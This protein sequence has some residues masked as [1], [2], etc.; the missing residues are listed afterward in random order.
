VTGPPSGIQAV[1]LYGPDGA[2]AYA[3][4]RGVQTGV[5]AVIVR[6]CAE[7]HAQTV[8]EIGCGTAAH[9]HAVQA[10]TG[11][12]GWGVDPSPSMLARRV[13][14]AGGLR[15]CC[16]CAEALPC[17]SGTVDVVFSV[18]VAH[19]VA[20]LD[21]AFHEG[22][23]VLRP[24]GLLLTATDSEAT[25]R[26]RPVLSGYFPETV[27]HELARY[28]S[29]GRLEVAHSRC[30][31]EIVETFVAE[32][33]YVVTDARPFRERAYSCLHLISDAALAAGI[34]RLERDLPLA[35]VSRNLVIIARRNRS[36]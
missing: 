2:A 4:F 18:D 12:R 28:P 8:L 23:R 32:H 11:C 24:G 7:C 27:T 16:A 6:L 15:L 17:G 19:H 1:L 14:D 36:A 20:D 35:T 5:L 26:A 33:P 34:A 3:A 9:L 30:G 21:V 31:L 10:L 25:I 22:A 29:V 13:P